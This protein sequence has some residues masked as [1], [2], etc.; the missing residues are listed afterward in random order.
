MKRV[1]IITKAT[2]SNEYLRMTEAFAA[3]LN[4]ESS[5]VAFTSCAVQDMLFGVQDGQL[6]ITFNGAELHTLCDVIHPRNANLFPDYANA[7]RLYADTFGIE[8]INRSDAVLPYY[9]KVSQG[10]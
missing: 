1:F 9:G 7:L 3:A 10:F 4:Q 5:N 8:L 6:T 2:K